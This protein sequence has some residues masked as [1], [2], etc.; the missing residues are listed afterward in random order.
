[1]ATSNKKILE[2]ADLAMSDLDT[3]G[4][5]M[6]PEQAN[7][8]IDMILE[9]PTILRQA[10]TQKMA[11][12]EMKVNRIGFGSRVLRAAPQGT[13]PHA[14]D[15]GTNDRY[16]AAAKRAAPVTSQISMETREVMAEVHLPYELFEDNI[17]G[18]GIESTIMRNLAKQLAIDFE[19]YALWADTSKVADDLLSLQD[20]WLKRMTSHVVNNASAG[21]SPDL[22][23]LGMLTMPQKY[24]RNIGEFR[25][26]LTLAET[27]RYRSLVA[28]RATGYGDSA[29]QSNIPLTAYGIPLE[30]A[31]LLTADGTGKT[32]FLTHPKNLLFGIQR[33]I[34]IETDK[35]IRSRQYIIVV[36]A[37]V[38]LQIEEEDM[39]VK[40]TNI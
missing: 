22:F 2:R 11:R 32:G 15:D 27:I 9:E 26:F 29:L 36:T 30:A 28:S 14:A 25:H 8:F 40:Y 17:E 12:R 7:T 19:E 5:A 13:P 24:M 10:R 16:L 35:D 20:G 6:D 21:V 31:H 37:R 1:M 34:S 23:E 18:A 4:G 33:D 38:A 3:N 39:T